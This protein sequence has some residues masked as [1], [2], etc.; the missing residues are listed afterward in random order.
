MKPTSTLTLPASLYAKVR[1]HLFPGDGLE[2]AAIL[3][4]SRVPGPRLRL[5][6]REAIFV[7]HDACS[8]RAPD[9]ITWPGEFVEHAIDQAEMDGLAIILIHSHP[10]GLFDFS[11]ADDASDAAVLPSLFHAFGELHGSAI[12]VPGGAIRARLYTPSM[13]NQLV[14]LVSVAGDDIQYWWS[15]LTSVTP[16]RRPVAFTSDMTA[17]VGR[18]TAGVI[19]VSGTGSIVAEQLARLG[20]ANVTLIDFD[21]LEHKNLNRILNSTIEGANRK[22]LKVNAFAAA[23]ASYRGEGVAYAVPASVVTREAVLAAS[24]C[25]VLFCCVDTLEARHIA[26]LICS[27]CLLPLFDVGVVIPTRSAGMTRAIGDVC[28]RID[29][30]QPGGST[31]QDRGVYSPVSL[32]AE[33]LRNAAPEAHREEQKAGYL[34]GMVDEA[35]AVIALNMRAASACVM[36]FIARAY[37]FRLEANRFYAR[38]Q[39]SLAACEEEYIAEDVFAKMPNPVLGRGSKEPLLGLPAL[40]ALVHEVAQ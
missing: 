1:D 28:G 32:R 3:L 17:E 26:D 40:K 2:A 19:G 5:L 9:A 27:A 34:Q 16:S 36:E 21:H 35:P 20:F 29:Y 6:A 30:V 39:F 31:L 25:D 23:I 12:M 24:Q 7:P 22:Q 8:H 37:P 15:D 38:T 11:D 33:Y 13:D 10:G 18:L 14:D 4:C